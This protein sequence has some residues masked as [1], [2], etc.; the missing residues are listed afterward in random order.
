MSIS[1]DEL[2]LAAS[3][4]WRA[5]EE[6]YL[7]DWLLRAAGGFTGRANSA[8]AVGDP[9]VPLPE[10]AGKVRAWYAER[11][12]TAMIAV[13]F[14]CGERGLSA[15]DRV[16]DDLG[17]TVRADGATVMTADS[18]EVPA[19]AGREFAGRAAATGP[20]DIDA[21]PDGAW[22]ARYHYRGVDQ[23]PPVALTVLTSAPWQAFASVRSGGETIAIGRVA[24]DDN[25]AGLTAIEVDPRHR[26]KGLG[27]AVTASLTFHAAS[28]GIRNVYLQ[29]ADGNDAARALYRRI[30]FTD[31]HGYHYRVEPHT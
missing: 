24:G 1:V 9:A 18:A 3:P 13:P 30:G 5:C 11:G 27:A 12:L 20:V 14:R 15:L 6:A 16:L 26:R 19:R 28:R 10:A 8:L 31:H 21:S 25:W 7:G 23:L 4:G 29:V 17:W 2:E 22:L